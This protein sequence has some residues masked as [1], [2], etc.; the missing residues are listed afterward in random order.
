M[1]KWLLAFFFVWPHSLQWANACK[2]EHKA[3]SPR[4]CCV[5]FLCQVFGQ[6]LL[7][8]WRVL[9]AIVALCVLVALMVLSHKDVSYSQPLPRIISSI[10]W[11]WLPLQRVIPLSQFSLSAEV[12]T[13][14]TAGRHLWWLQGKQ[15]ALWVPLSDC[16]TRCAAAGWGS[17]SRVARILMS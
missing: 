7:S 10:R 14:H 16:K 12:H 11:P 9:V 8:Q 5:F 3:Q 1:S 2:I 17:E 13:H 15:S 6:I 4:P